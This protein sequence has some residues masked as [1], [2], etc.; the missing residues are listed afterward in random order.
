[1]AVV[2][3]WWVS[4]EQCIDVVQE[5]RRAKAGGRAQAVHVQMC[6]RGLE[7]HP[8][9][10]NYLVPMLAECDNVIHAQQIFYKLRHRN[11]HSWTSLIQGYVA[12]GEYEL[13]L[14]L[15]PEMHKDCVLPGRHTFAALLKACAKLK[16]LPRG[17]YLHTDVT[18][19]MLESDS[20]IGNTLINLYVKCESLADARAIFDELPTR[21]IV[22]WNALIG[23]YADHGLGKEVLRCVEDMQ[24]EGLSPDAFTCISTLKLVAS[25]SHRS[26]PRVTCQQCQTGL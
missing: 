7:A 22:S 12:C 11:E 10:G 14:A 20:I 16:D 24:R 5:C 21:T 2:E 23:G 3:Q 6:G 15:F 4:V 19:E 9:V 1:M 17:Q 18:T 13:A 26:G 8:A 25:L